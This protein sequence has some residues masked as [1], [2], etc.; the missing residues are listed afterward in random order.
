[1][2]LTD[3]VGGLRARFE[4]RLSGLQ[5]R[6]LL[7]VDYWDVHNFSSE[8]ARWDYGS[9]HHAVMG[10]G[11]CT[12]VG[13]ATITWTDTFYSYGVEVL[14]GRIEDTLILGADGPER[15]G[16]DAGSGS[17]W[18]RYLRTPIRD[19]AAHWERVELG[20]SRRADGTV[21]EP[22]SAVDVP[23][24][25]RL[26]FIEGKVWF[27]AAMPEPPEGQRVFVGGDE[28]MVVFSREK[29]RDMGFNDITFLQ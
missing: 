20:P 25:L 12:D 5:G 21:V 19:T 18:D 24:A 26:D 11:L 3:E 15:V 23:L 13:P 9:W 6:R 8:P 14:D 2:G 16:H 22:A 7:A 28:I 27:V 4:A 29:M 17:P 1:M 10:V